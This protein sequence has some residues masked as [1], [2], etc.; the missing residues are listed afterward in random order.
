MP[1]DC[2][3]A[4]RQSLAH[5]INGNTS[6]HHRGDEVLS[7]VSGFNIACQRG[8]THLLDRRGCGKPV[9]VSGNRQRRNFTAEPSRL[10]VN[11]ALRIGGDSEGDDR[12]GKARQNFSQWREVD[13]SRNSR[14]QSNAE[15]WNKEQHQ[16]GIDSLNLALEPFHAEQPTVHL[17]GLLN[18][19]AAGLVVERPKHRHQD[20][21]RHQLQ[22]RREPLR[23]KCFGKVAR[24]TRWNVDK[25]PASHPKNERGNGHENARNT[26]SPA[27][28]PVFEQPRSQERGKKRTEVNCEVEPSKNSLKQV[29]VCR[30]KLIADMR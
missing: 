7:P 4:G 23:P 16:K 27:R 14:V 5:P 8:Q 9:D 30:A 3:P 1:S 18:P 20:I 15:K 12:D 25:P 17:L 11:P 10:G 28:T 24:P 26:K 29:A 2:R 6:G 21:E 13:Q 22:N 19:R